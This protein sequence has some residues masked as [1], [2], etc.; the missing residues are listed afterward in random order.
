[1]QKSIAIELDKRVQ[2]VAENFSKKD[3][4]GNVNG[5]D[6]TIKSRYALSDHAA[7][8]RFNKTTTKDALALFFYDDGYPSTSRKLY[9]IFRSRDMS[10]VK[11]NTIG[12]H[13]YAGHPIAKEYVN[14]ITGTN[15]L[16]LRNTLGIIIRKALSNV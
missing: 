3:R 6:F 9:Y 10:K 16:G 1:M 11:N 5:E 12:L 14:S 15:F 7:F 13:W 4:V 2:K 8:V